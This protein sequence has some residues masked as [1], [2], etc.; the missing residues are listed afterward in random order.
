MPTV[1]VEFQTR[2]ESDRA[3]D[4]LEFAGFERERIE[5]IEAADG[6]WK[7]GIYV[8]ERDV[9][10]ARAVMSDP[11]VPNSTDP[12]NSL[13]IFGIATMAR[14]VLPYLPRGFE[15]TS[16]GGPRPT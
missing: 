1:W 3:V 16:H 14:L 2:D 15:G 11:N 4:R 7:V 9:P 6:R 8:E 12:L 10:N 5:R 13:L